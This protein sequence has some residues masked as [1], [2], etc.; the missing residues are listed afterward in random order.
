MTSGRPSTTTEDAV[1]SCDCASFVRSSISVSYRDGLRC[2]TAGRTTLSIAVRFG[3]SVWICVTKPMVRL[4]KIDICLSFNVVTSLPASRI[5]PDVG[6]SNPVTRLSKVLLP[7]PDLPTIA[8][9]SPGSSVRFTSSTAGKGLP[10]RTN[11]RVRP[12]TSNMGCSG[13]TP[14][15]SASGMPVGRKD[16]PLWRGMRPGP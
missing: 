15:P 4:R 1:C 11:S 16:A 10:R 6:V 5:A 14:P 9:N 8:M 2:S 7:F 13:I 3:N 12:R